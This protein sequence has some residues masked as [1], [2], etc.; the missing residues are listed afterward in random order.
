MHCTPFPNNAGTQNKGSLLQA[1][2]RALSRN[3]ISQHLD[4]RLYSLQNC[5][6]C[7]LYC[8]VAYTARSMVLYYSNP[9]S[10]NSE[11]LF[12]ALSPEL[13]AKILI[14]AKKKILLI[15]VDVYQSM[16]E[17]NYLYSVQQ[18]QCVMA[19]REEMPGT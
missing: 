8:C 16:C 15:F 13:W 19:N 11:L 6:F 5:L 17:L 12:N 1:Q 10:P 9:S 2:K 14:T 7:C 18:S 3:Q 4:L